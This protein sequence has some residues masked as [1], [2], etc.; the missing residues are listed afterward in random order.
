MDVVRKTG[1]VSVNPFNKCPYLTLNATPRSN[2]PQAKVRN[3]TSSSAPLSHPSDTHN[4]SRPN[5]VSI[6][7]PRSYVH[8]LRNAS[9]PDALNPPS[10][11]AAACTFAAN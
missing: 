4:C 7:A 5:G 3:A 1:R 10:D 2:L 11:V 8:V 6:S 9:G